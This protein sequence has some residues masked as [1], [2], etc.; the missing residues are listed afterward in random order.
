METAR[1]N[2]AVVR[3]ALSHLHKLY[4]DGQHGVSEP[5]D[6]GPWFGSLS[7]DVVF[8][9]PCATAPAADDPAAL[10]PPWNVIGR[11]HHGLDAV[12]TAFATDQEDI[13]DWQVQH[14]PQ[15]FA[16]GD[17]VVVLHT[18][19][20][21]IARSGGEQVPWTHSAMVF[22]VRHGKIVRYTHIADMSGHVSA[23]AA[24][25]AGA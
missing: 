23:H 5:V 9:V 4:E 18:E 16:D 19:R 11:E 3:H 21:A 13:R 20:Y 2:V 10:Q 25:P 6:F 7:N 22:D 12:K 1:E 17:R 15:Y 8:Y 14:A 24:A